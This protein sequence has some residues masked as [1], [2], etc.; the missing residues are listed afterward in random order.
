M[1]SCLS[2]NNTPSRVEQEGTKPAEVQE[3]EEVQEIPDDREVLDSNL[4]F[5]APSGFRDQGLP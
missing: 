3:P 5:L 2:S 1:G 4:K